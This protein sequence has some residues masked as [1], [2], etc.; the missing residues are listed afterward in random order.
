MGQK[1]LSIEISMNPN[2]KVLMKITAFNNTW[3]VI[4]KFA[5][6]IKITWGTNSSYTALVNTKMTAGKTVKRLL[7]INHMQQIL[8][9][10]LLHT[11]QSIIV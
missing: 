8:C 4:F 2:I 3:R 9:S 11:I 5:P 1:I 10:M 6:N 7:N